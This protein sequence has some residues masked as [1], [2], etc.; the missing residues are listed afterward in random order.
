MRCALPRRAQG[1][2]EPGPEAV[3][4][5]LFERVGGRTGDRAGSQADRER[6]SLTPRTGGALQSSATRRQTAARAASAFATSCKPALAR[7]ERDA[8]S[9]T[10]DA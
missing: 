1:T 10:P 6:K 7:V 9:R 3:H 8:Q 2:S 5:E 4:D